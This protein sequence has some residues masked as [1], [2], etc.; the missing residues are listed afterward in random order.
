MADKKKICK[1]LSSVEMPGPTAWMLSCHSDKSIARNTPA[2]AA[3]RNA[4]RLC[5]SFCP[6][7]RIS[8]QNTTAATASRQNATAYEPTCTN[9]TIRLPSPNTTQPNTNSGAA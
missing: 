5:G 4:R 1:L 2:N 9:F 7:W 8:S 3:K 6:K